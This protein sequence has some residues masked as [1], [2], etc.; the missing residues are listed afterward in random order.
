M[1]RE[2]V[3]AKKVKLSQEQ[4][5]SF[6]EESNSDQELM[7]LYE[8]QE[9][10]QETKEKTS[11]INKESLGTMLEAE[12]ISDASTQ[13]EEYSQRYDDDDMAQCVPELVVYTPTQPKEKPAVNETKRGPRKKFT[14]K[15]QRKTKPLKQP[16]SV[17]PQEL[18]SESDDFHKS[19][20]EGTWIQCSKIDCLKWR[21]LPNNVEPCT[22]P[23]RW[24]CAMNSD[25]S[26]TEC[27]ASQETCDSQLDFDVVYT[28]FV[29]GSLVWAKVPGYPW[30]PGM[31]EDDPDYHCCYET[32]DT[33]VNPISYHVSFI[34]DKD[35]SRSWVSYLNITRLWRIRK[36]K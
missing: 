18:K 31:V 21:K 34:F 32:D 5:F 19:K 28:P 27:T 16:T 7:E 17:S 6:G 35:V 4:C 14:P 9:T 23:E 11:E 24:V 8:E 22:I 13:S 3:K 15:R 25:L 2:K 33:N 26:R 29:A 10:L 36:P 20:K 12:D 1:V 30:W